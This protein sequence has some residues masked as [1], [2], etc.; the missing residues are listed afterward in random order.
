MEVAGLVQMGHSLIS[1]YPFFVDLWAVS[2]VE[3]EISACLAIKR[4]T[5]AYSTSISGA[6]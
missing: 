1:M 4:G 5:G 6:V 3:D 2:V